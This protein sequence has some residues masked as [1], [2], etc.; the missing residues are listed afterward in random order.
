MTFDYYY[1]SQA[2]QFSFIRIPRMLLT[3]ETFS[4]L[5]L[6]S[7]MLY[8]ILLDR[9]SLSMKNGWFD[10]ENRA[11]IIYQ[12]SEIQSDLGFSRKKAMD[13]LTELEKFGLVEKK[14]RGFGLPS[15]IYVKSF[16]IQEKLARGIETRTSGLKMPDARGAEIGTSGLA[17][18]KS[19]KNWTP[20][21]IGSNRRGPEI[22]T[23]RSP[24]IDISGGSQIVTSEVPKS[25]LLEVPE[26]TPLMNKTNK[27]YTD[28]SYIESNQILSAKVGGSDEDE[29][30]RMSAYRE[31]VFENI[32]L[33][34]LKQAHP[35]DAELLDGIY[36]LILEVLL[37][38][39][40]TTVIASNE[41][42]TEL[43]KSKFMKL[44]YSH[45]EYALDCFSSNSTKVRNIKKYMLAILFNAPST[46]SG[47][48]TAEVH[49]DMP[50]LAK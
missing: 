40:P 31:I 10:E 8:S 34:D 37:S 18:D 17:A 36:D 1:G 15:I 44:T 9:M 26:S 38:K 13:Y 32:A 49:H 30:R 20:E 22:D 45:I 16:M 29:M 47:Y 21:M 19:T 7:K 33:D 43:V 23:T 5:S 46:I 24:Q 42:P 3:E 39:S 50:A 25:T 2:D 41:Y 11:Y 27:N 14:K 48:Y 35:Y 12:I 6:Q 28:W 4:P